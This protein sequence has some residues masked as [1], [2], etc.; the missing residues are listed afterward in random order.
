[1]GVRI[2]ELAKEVGLTSKEVIDFI[3]S[4][5]EQYGL[6]VKSASN[7]IANLYADAIKGDILKK[8]GEKTEE[9]LSEKNEPAPE[10]KP[11]AKVEEKPEPAAEKKPEEAEVSHMPAQNIVEP[12]RPAPAPKIPPMQKRPAPLPPR[13]IA[14]PAVQKPV[15]AAKAPDLPSARIIQPEVVVR[16]APIC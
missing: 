12:K 8:S 2:H 10:P 11:E 6:E 9:A 3:N 5:K 13:P 16:E 4:R 1:M 14:H 15:E 7:S